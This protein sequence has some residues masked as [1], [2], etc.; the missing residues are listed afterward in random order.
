MAAVLGHGDPSAV[1][2]DRPFQDLGFDSLTAVELRNLLNRSTG[3]R[4]SASLV[5]DHPT[6]AAVARH[7]R[8]LLTVAQT[9]P[10]EQVTVQL[11]RLTS[12]VRQAAADPAAFGEITAGLYAL[13]EAAEAAAGRRAA[14]RGGAEGADGADGTDAAGP[15]L[16]SASDEELFALINDFD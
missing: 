7:L 10:G 11:G 1:G 13:L 8:Q 2:T 15:A 16:D 3:L 14:D 12:A 4:L 9:P 5:F 6:P